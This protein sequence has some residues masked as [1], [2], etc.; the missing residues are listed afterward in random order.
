M[1]ELGTFSSVVTWVQKSPLDELKTIEGVKE[2]NGIYG[3]YDIL[4]KVEV[5]DEHKLKEI[6]TYKIR[7]M[8]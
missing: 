8:N 7:K 4:V 3:V 1:W 5:Q 2:V 6:I